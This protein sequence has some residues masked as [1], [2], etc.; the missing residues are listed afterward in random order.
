MTT[1]RLGRGGRRVRVGVEGDDQNGRDNTGHEQHGDERGDET[2][3]AEAFALGLLGV[4]R[5]VLAFSDVSATAERRLGQTGRAQHRHHGQMLLLLVLLMML[6]L[7]Y[8]MLV[9]VLLLLFLAELAMETSDD[10]LVAVVRIVV[11]VVVVADAVVEGVGERSFVLVVAACLR[12]RHVMLKLAGEI[13]TTIVATL[14]SH[15]NRRVEDRRPLLLHE[16]A[17][18]VRLRLIVA[19]VVERLVA[20]RHHERSR[21]QAVL[22]MSVSIERINQLVL[23]LMKYVLHWLLILLLLLLLLLLLMV[24]VVM[25]MEIS[26]RREF[27]GAEHSR[28][29]CWLWQHRHLRL[30]AIRIRV[31]ARRSKER[32]VGGCG[33]GLW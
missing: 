22:V 2:D 25:M 11:V 6:H 8:L 14:A 26:D 28:G 7:L 18:R 21:V 29:V 4:T 27:C 20:R 23:R 10:L 3:E 32:V 13:V 12:R 31:G 30:A 15:H 19:D 24:V 33:G 16:V 5:L 17:A 1:S 9:I